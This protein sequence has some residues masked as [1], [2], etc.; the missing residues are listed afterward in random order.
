MLLLEM[1]H[2]QDA[3]YSFGDL[4]QGQFV[5]A[6]VMELLGYYQVY[7]HQHQQPYLPDQYP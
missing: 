7:W 2:Y 1:G 3:S 5:V 6:A 4:F